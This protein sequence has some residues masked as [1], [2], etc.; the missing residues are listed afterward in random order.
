MIR[1]TIWTAALAV[2]LSPLFFVASAHAAPVPKNDDITNAIVITEPSFSD[3]LN[4]GAATTAPDDPVCFGN[5]T[6]VWY[7]YTPAVDERI[8]LD[9]FGS[10]YDTTL[11]VYTE[12]STEPL[13]QV[14][15][16]DDA[17][18]ALSAIEF[19]ASAGVT[20]FFMVGS[21]G[22]GN[23]GGATRF[24]FEVDPPLEL[25]VQFDSGFLGEIEDAFLGYTVTC[26]RPAT[27]DVS[28][29]LTQ[30]S[31]GLTRSAPF[32]FGPINCNYEVSD[33]VGPL[34]PDTG[35]FAPG[36][37]LVDVLASATALDDGETVE[38]ADAQKIKL[39]N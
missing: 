34:F 21:F 13:T 3:K 20:Y 37:A 1:S 2:A 11:S 28:G 35:A 9:T 27:V 29:L 14:A 23:S 8:H 33:G 6:T 30:K 22:S 26:S 38:F 31:K 36:N 32:E 18:R 7:A 25:S 39:G 12:G 16:N 5:S 17:V 19:Q 15:C 10:S 24:N 4:T